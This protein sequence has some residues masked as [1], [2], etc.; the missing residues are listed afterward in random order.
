MVVAICVAIVAA[1]V[2]VLAGTGHLVTIQ[3]SG[4][5]TVSVSKQGAVKVTGGVTSKISGTVT[6]KATG[7]TAI[8]GTVSSQ[9]VAPK[10]PFYASENLQ[11]NGHQQLLLWQGTTPND[12]SI[13]NITVSD[14]ET[15][16]QFN[17]YLEV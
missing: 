1:P 7:T 17:P 3:G 15:S 9:P 6:T 12:L 4:H 16:G 2:G 14:S 5:H 11:T 10:Y 13:T 8:S